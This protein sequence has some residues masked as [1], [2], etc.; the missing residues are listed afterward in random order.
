VPLAD[1]DSPNAIAAKVFAAE[2][3]AYPE[4]LNRVESLGVDYF[5]ARVGQ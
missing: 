1:D 2:C 5:W 3:L 4:A